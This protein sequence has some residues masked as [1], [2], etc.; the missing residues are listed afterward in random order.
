MV[1]TSEGLTY[2]IPISVGTL[3]TMNNKS[4]INSLIQFL[5]L[6]YVK[7]KTAVHR[8][9]ADKNK[10]KEISMGSALWSSFHKR[11]KHKKPIPV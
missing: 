4:A 7:Q 11:R 5:V 6:L 1:S 3:V 10:P 8:L 2:N 9:G